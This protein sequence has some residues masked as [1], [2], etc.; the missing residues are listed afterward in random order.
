M[1]NQVI[2][3]YRTMKTFNALWFF[4][5]LLL[6]SSCDQGSKDQNVESD[7]ITLSAG[8]RNPYEMAMERQHLEEV[9][10][11]SALELSN[12][13][14]LVFLEFIP[15]GWSSS[16][17]FAYFKGTGSG[18]AGLGCEQ[19]MFY[20]QDMTTDRILYNQ[21]FE[22]KTMDHDV[23][24]ELNSYALHDLKELLDGYGI[25]VTYNHTLK[26]FPYEIANWRYDI[27]LYCSEG[28]DGY[29]DGITDVKVVANASHLGTAT[30]FRYKDFLP[31]RP[32]VA[33]YLSGKG[34][35]IA[36]I[37]AYLERGFENDTDVDCWVVGCDLTEG[38]SR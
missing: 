10:F 18:S 30:I 31:A 35:K 22:C 5:L 23:K 33:G 29:S 21:L 13:S 14:H 19:Y 27:K 32:V 28:S 26:Q 20:V 16:G 37:V 25:D 9:E 38:Y 17:Y 1:N 4:I 12:Y 2:I 6:F 15:V 36:V 3:N 8:Y 7:T 24:G 34:N 11:H